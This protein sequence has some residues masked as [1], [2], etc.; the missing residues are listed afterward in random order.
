VYMTHR[1][2]INGNNRP[3]S[4]ARMTSVTSKYNS[5]QQQTTVM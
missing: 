4:P 3:I 1:F 2:S 5:T